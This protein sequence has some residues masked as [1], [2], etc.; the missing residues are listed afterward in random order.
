MASDSQLCAQCRDVDI[1]SL[2]TGVLDHKEAIALGPLE[3]IISKKEEC[4]LCAAFVA[5]FQAQQPWTR[6]DAGRTL[7][8]LRTDGDDTNVWLYSYVIMKDKSPVLR[9][10]LSTNKNDQINRRG[11][12]K[13]AGDIQLMQSSA[14]Q[15]SIALQGRGRSISTT[16]D[17]DLARTWLDE[18]V[19]HHDVLCSQPGSSALQ[20]SAANVP[21][22]LRMIDVYDRRLV[23]LPQDAKYVALSYCWPKEPGLTNTSTNGVD[24]CEKRAISES[25]GL[26]TAIDDACNAVRDLKERYLWV[27]ALCIVQDDL[28]DKAHQIGQMDLVYGN[29][30][31]TI[32]IAPSKHGTEYSGLPG[33]CSASSTRYQFIRRIP[34]QDIE[35]AV[36]KPCLED[37]LAYTRWE[38]RG[39][40]FQESHISRRSLYFTDHQLYFQ[41]SCG[42][43]CEDTI[44]EWHTPGAYIKHSTNIWNP[45]NVHGADGEINYGEISLGHTA[46]ADDNEALSMYGNLVSAYLR[47]ELSFRTD[48]LNAFEGIAKVLARAMDTDFYAGLPVKWLD[49]G[50][51]WQLY[52]IADRQNGF[53]SFS[54]AGWQGGAEA[55]YWLAADSTRRLVTWHRLDQVG[56]KR[57]E[58]TS[59]FG[60]PEG[61]S[62]TIP[63][64]DPKALSH[65]PSMLPWSL[66]TSTQVASFSL[67][68][69]PIEVAD[70]ALWPNG[71]HVW[72]LDTDLQNAGVILVDKTWKIRK[73]TQGAR[74]D[75]ILLSR[76]QRSR[77]DDI[78]NFD[79]SCY[80][81]R[82]WCLLN[83]MLVEWRDDGMAER[84]AVGT[85]HYDAW[86]EADCT[87]KPV[88]LC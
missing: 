30:L 27:D 82:E 57:C 16:T 42:M 17:M 4:A 65:T 11:R 83:V 13:H 80:E 39:W 35:I 24:L 22:H 75:F 55:P 7:E 25:N 78:P 63:G 28:D 74:H 71:E 73:V 86:M 45:K 9:V 51:L 85:V 50:L 32:V 33:Y 58:S 70:T 61:S 1:A 49:H 14:E 37:I 18:C 64:L 54:W 69:I 15:L 38:T 43:R 8:L 60:E 72:I 77:N 52:G 2:F 40:T 12:R 23:D 46:Y 76:A 36:P 53:P 48:I 44:I 20:P 41:C 66:A 6:F 67:S 29:A 5:S 31:L 87:T 34:G 21:T 10:G 19:T 26:S 62:L 88:Q 47:R 81:Q 56:W 68:M 3:N 84:I 79:D 59:E